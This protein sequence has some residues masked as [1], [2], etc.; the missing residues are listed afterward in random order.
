MGAGV[1]GDPD[2]LVQDLDRAVGNA[3]LD[4]LADET[5]RHGVVVVG[6]LDVVVGR[7]PAP[8]PFGKGVRLGRQRLECR[9]VD[10]REQLVPADAEL[11]HDLGVE[12]GD[13]LAD[14]LVELG[15]REEAPVTQP[16][17]HVALDDEDG[18]FDLG[19]VARLARPRR[20]DRGG[21]MLGQFLI[22]AVDARFVAAGRR[23]PSL[24]V[25]A[26]HRLGDAADVGEGVGVG[27]DPVGKPLRPAGLGVGV[28]RSAEHRDED[29]GSLL[30]P[31]GGVEDRNRVASEVHE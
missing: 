30:G 8:P 2:A 13:N 16:G 1:A 26:N 5:E 24:Q 19:F 10:L 11:A 23:D 12:I 28:V 9:P 17:E 25:V 31:T 15:E 6:D 27:A 20:Q 21:V 29:V 4:L 7:D 22:G 18:D 14:R 3:R